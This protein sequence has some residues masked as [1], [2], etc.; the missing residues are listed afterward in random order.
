MLP[1]IKDHPITHRVI[2][3]MKFVVPCIFICIYQFKLGESLASNIQQFPDP[4][5]YWNNT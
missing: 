2:S 5:G 1:H 4:K 3:I